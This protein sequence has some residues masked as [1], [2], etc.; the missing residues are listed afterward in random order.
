MA[1]PSRV[2]DSGSY[3]SLNIGNPLCYILGGTL[4]YIVSGVAILVVGVIITSVTFQ[5]LDHHNDS[6][7]ERYAG[8][9]LIVVG[10]LI[11]GK[12]AVFRIKESECRILIERRWQGFCRRLAVR[13][14][15]MEFVIHVITLKYRVII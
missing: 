7:K 6:N 14:K 8:P 12:G 11:M 10:I 2:M 15:F 1:R 3:M 13:K 9:I 4:C 5:N